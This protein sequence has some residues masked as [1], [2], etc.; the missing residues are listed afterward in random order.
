MTES[1]NV[2]AS[3]GIDPGKLIWQI[4]NFGIL[5]FVLSKVLYKPILQKLDQRA[6][7]IKDGIKAA[8]E[9]IQK[10]EEADAQRQKMLQDAR[11]DVEVL[12][13]KAKKD[14]LSAKDE[15][16]AEAKKE[17]AKLMDRKEKEI[18][19][20]MAASEKALQSKVVDLSVSVAR[21]AL[22]QYL[23]SSKQEELVSKQLEQLAKT[24]L[25]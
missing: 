4:V 16:L 9:N 20:K 12:I 1:A 18:E 15:I 6:K 22:E 13:A 24:K 10:Q 21:K 2:F 11:K 3:L 25:K 14:A 23:D 17:A 5:L 8:N 7:L 19:D